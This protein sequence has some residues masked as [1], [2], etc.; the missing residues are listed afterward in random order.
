[1]LK[2]FLLTGL[3]GGVVAL[4]A[5]VLNG[6]LPL[7]S[8]KDDVQQAA[9][10]VNLTEK[11]IAKTAVQA[12]EAS[13]A[14]NR[15]L[16]TPEGRQQL[17]QDLKTFEADSQKLQKLQGSLAKDIN[18]YE[19]AG[20]ANQTE[21]QGELGQIKDSYTKRKVERIHE[22]AYQS[23][24]TIAMDARAALAAIQAVQGQGED[25]RHA[26]RCINLGNQ[27]EAD[28][29]DLQQQVETV[30][31]AIADYGRR[32]SDLLAKLSVGI[33]GESE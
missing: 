2:R 28:G 13:A 25:L 23:F 5:F 22:Q 26:A 14:I 17:P 24:T 6:S 4:A 11:E 12:K 18:A 19:A 8:A 10:Q 32:T 16:A 33:G 7:A 20:T 27:L 29:R 3:T 21:Y 30:K 15:D 1:M 31:M 9:G